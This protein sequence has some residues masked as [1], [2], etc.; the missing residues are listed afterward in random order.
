MEKM[1][2]FTVLLE[3]TAYYEKEV[4]AYSEEEAMETAVRKAADTRWSRTGDWTIKSCGCTECHEKKHKTTCT[5]LERFMASD[6][7]WRERLEQGT[8]HIS[9]KIDREFIFAVIRVMF[10]NSYSPDD[11]DFAMDDLCEGIRKGIDKTLEEM[12]AAGAGARV[13]DLALGHLPERYA[14][15]PEV[16]ECFERFGEELDTEA[17]YWPRDGRRKG[18]NM[19]DNY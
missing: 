6:L 10:L 7:A 13:R 15:C 2:R 4:C 16:I 11:M 17:I 18:G 9:G 12:S 5:P 1:K 8:L 19:H 14:S 3:D